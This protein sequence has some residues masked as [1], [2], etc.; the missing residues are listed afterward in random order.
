MEFT[1]QGI[2]VVSHWGKIYQEYDRQ[3]KKGCQAFKISP[4]EWKNS[5]LGWGICDA[6]QRI[7]TNVRLR[8]LWDL[9]EIPKKGTDCAVVFSLMECYS[10]V[11]TMDKLGGEG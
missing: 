11:D 10:S 4:R 8:I 9:D 3:D 1:F 7:L 6:S 5:L 2:T